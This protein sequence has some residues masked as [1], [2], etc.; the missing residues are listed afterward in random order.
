MI[1]PELELRLQTI[2]AQLQRAMMPIEWMTPPDVERYSKGKYRLEFVRD[3]IKQAM[4][5]PAESLFKLGD[6]YLV[7]TDNKGVKITVN[8]PE[9]DRLVVESISKHLRLKA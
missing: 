3:T 8:Y 5:N 1:D 4:V 9:F 7:T 2:E 6:H